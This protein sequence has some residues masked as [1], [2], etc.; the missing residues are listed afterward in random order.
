MKTIVLSIFF[1]G[2]GSISAFAQTTPNKAAAEEGVYTLT[3]D[4]M[5]A[6]VEEADRRSISTTKLPERIVEQLKYS[7]LAG[8]A[9]VGATEI[10]PPFGEEEDVQYE[11]VLQESRPGKSG[12]LL[13]RYDFFGKLISQKEVPNKQAAPVGTAAAEG[14]AEVETAADQK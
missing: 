14:T 9:I 11:L 6:T 8:H 12:L 1:V 5:S 7:P 4:R 2:L 13:V 3:M 10:M